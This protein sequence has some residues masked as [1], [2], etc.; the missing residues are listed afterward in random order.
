MADYEKPM[1]R[2]RD[3]IYREQQENATE[4]DDT[5]WYDI[6]DEN[7]ELKK[8]LSKCSITDEIDKHNSQNTVRN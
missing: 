3:I 5:D 2:I 1:E 6:D 7:V 8:Q 4:D